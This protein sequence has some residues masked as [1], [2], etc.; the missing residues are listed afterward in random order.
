LLVLFALSLISDN[1]LNHFSFEEH[2]KDK[3]QYVKQ[4]TE[5]GIKFL[6]LICSNA[7]I[8]HYSLHY[9]YKITR[10]SKACLWVKVFQNNIKFRLNY[11][12]CHCFLRGV[13]MVFQ[14]L[15]SQYDYVFVLK[16]PLVFINS[17]KVSLTCQLV[18]F[19]NF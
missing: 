1:D 3:G 11:I 19:L 5:R 17:D 10:L 4:Y 7:I 12:F 15:L 2:F 13:Q 9:N 18:I 14:F 16:I 8:F 6:K